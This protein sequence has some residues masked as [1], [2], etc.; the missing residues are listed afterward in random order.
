MNTEQKVNT[1]D[2][3]ARISSLV[4]KLGGILF[5]WPLAWLV[6]GTIVQGA[7]RQWGSSLFYFGSPVLAAI[8]MVIAVRHYPAS[9]RFLTWFV[10]ITLVATI[11]TGGFYHC[12]KLATD[13]SLLTTMV[14]LY[15]RYSHTEPSISRLDTAATLFTSIVISLHHPDQDWRIAIP[16]ISA[17]ITC[18]SSMAT[19]Y[20]VLLLLITPPFLAM[21]V[22]WLWVI[23]SVL[24]VVL[25]QR[26]WGWMKA[27]VI[28]F[29][30][31]P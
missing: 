7:G 4:G 17:H 9:R 15:S 18:Y 19:P 14:D 8:M 27:A 24:Y 23:L 20:L 1:N 26:A 16:I 12:A 28:R 21:P 31:R 2:A 5:W 10:A 11:L 22:F 30:H 25:P 13:G 29:R 3:D 6:F